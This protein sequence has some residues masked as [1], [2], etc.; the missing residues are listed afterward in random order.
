MNY[1]NIPF[2]LKQQHNW[3]CANHTS[4]VPMQTYTHAAASSTDPNTWSSFED[5]L[6]AVQNKR[7]EYIGF[8]FADTGIVGIDIDAGYEDDLPSA[9]AVDIIGHCRSYTEKSKSGRGFHILLKGDL[10]FKGRNNLAGVEIYKTA[11]YFI[12]TGDT[13][14]FKSIEENQT[15]IDY[16]I[17]KY[18]P[19]TRESTF[20]QMGKRI[21]SPKWDPISGGKLKLRPKYP[22]ITQG[23][24][25]MCLTSL[26]GT[27]HSQGYSKE[28]IYKELLYANKTACK[29]PLRVSEVRSVVNS[30][31]RYT[32]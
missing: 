1:Q 12:M 6:K 27:L 20:G 11:R 15:A 29:P 32:R 14:L 19:E 3:V 17:A 18:F 16:V 10:P 31:M 26:A 8:V 13:I 7:Y 25:N 5:A 22:E 28:Q 21:Y 9:L 24:R 4:K 30:V 23:G 2:E